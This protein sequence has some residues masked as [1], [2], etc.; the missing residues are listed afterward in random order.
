ML[1]IVNG[2][3]NFTARRE[4]LKKW[5]KAKTKVLITE[6]TTLLNKF[7]QII[8]PALIQIG[9]WMKSM[10][11]KMCGFIEQFSTTIDLIQKIF[12]NIMSKVATGGGSSSM[13]ADIVFNTF[14]IFDVQHTGA[15][16]EQDIQD[17]ANL[18]SIAAL[19]G[20]K[21]RAMFHK[22]DENGDGGLDRQE[23]S[24]MMEDPT[25]PS[26]M[27]Y[28]LRSFAKKLTEIAGI[29]K[30]ARKR[31]EVAT[32]L[33]NYLTLMTAKN[34]TKVSWVSQTLTNGSVPIELSV[35][36]FRVL[37]DQQHAPAKVTNLPA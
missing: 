14:A 18:Y 9:K 16:T 36:V 30:G 37:A 13:K 12:D 24:N 10:G 3:T 8:K 29:L 1:A 20:A 35:D 21:G 22:Y 28:V 11:D 33:A 32:S 15:I 34:L 7:L 25:L 27:T 6:L 4:G 31:D 17:T 5:V 2:T 23:Y 19:Q 26:C